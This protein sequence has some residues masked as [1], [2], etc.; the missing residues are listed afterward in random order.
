VIADFRALISPR[1]VEERGMSGH[2]FQLAI[3]EYGTARISVRSTLGSSED[4][5]LGNF[6]RVLFRVEDQYQVHRILLDF[7][8]VPYFGA[9]CM[10]IIA[11]FA[12]RCHKKQTSVSLV[13]DSKSLLAV[14]NLK[15]RLIESD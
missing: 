9:R 12:S 14:C 7:S 6:A 13:G 4:T 5:N 11:G 2:E 8:D 15:H 1:I 3:D 10:G